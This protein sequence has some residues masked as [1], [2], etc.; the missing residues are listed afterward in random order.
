MNWLGIYLRPLLRPLSLQIHLFLRAKS[1]QRILRLE[2]V[3][4]H[5]LRMVIPLE[6]L[7]IRHILWHFIVSST[8][9]NCLVC[10]LLWMLALQRQFWKCA[11]VNQSRIII[12]ILFTLPLNNLW[13]LHLLRVWSILSAALAG[14]IASLIAADDGV[15]VLVFYAVGVVPLLTVPLILINIA[16]EMLVAFDRI[17]DYG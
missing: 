16:T 12:A 7:Q 6:P 8:R 9:R 5:W 15:A 3:N 10:Y 14:L 2:R 17:V 11:L 1:R 4:L 13:I